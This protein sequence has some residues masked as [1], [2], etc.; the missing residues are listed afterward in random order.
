M[1]GDE[2]R[3]KEIPTGLPAE[4]ALEVASALSNVLVP[5]I[6]G[7]IANVLSGLAV[8]RKI[9]RVNEVVEGL[10]RDLRDFKSAAS[11]AYVKTDAFEDLLE[12]TLR[13]AAEERS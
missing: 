12:R 8:G 2:F 13:Q 1:G 3:Y 4:T 10:G 9:D 11:E 7:P 6:G 5:W